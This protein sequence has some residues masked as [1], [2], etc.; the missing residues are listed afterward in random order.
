M[1]GHSNEPG[2]GVKL[3]GSFAGRTAVVTGAGGEIG[4]ACAER[5]AAEGARVLAVD[6]DEG[7][8]ERTSAEI[9]AAGGSCE[10]FVGDVTDPAN[11][12]AY[13]RRGATLGDGHIDAF[14]NNAGV[15][16]PVR[17]TEEY[18]V[19]DFDAVLAVNVR[20]VFLGMRAILPRMRAGGAIV[21][22][23]SSA[24]V[25][26]VPGMV[27]YAAAK[28]AVLGMTRT[29]AR[30]AAPRGIRVNAV[31]PGPIEGRMTRSLEQ[32]TGLE[33]AHERFVAGVP[34]RR[35]GKPAEVAAAVAFLL[36]D[37]A[38]FVTGAAYIIDGGQTLG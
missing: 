27:G 4:R 15:E 7:S 11:V 28:H 21:N 25:S 14:F 12:E 36:S 24:S 30:E 38:S 9:V 33:R 1:P 3:V 35:F 19:E 18:P 10:S 32:S 8:V 37:E 26:G 17:R 20:G 29:T 2:S 6:R 22:T 16:G 5:L 31:C 34:L 13:A 23:G